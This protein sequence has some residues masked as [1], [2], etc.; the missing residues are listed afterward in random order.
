MIAPLFS[1]SGKFLNENFP[2]CSH[3]IH[4]KVFFLLGILRQSLLPTA[5][6]IPRITLFAVAAAHLFVHYYIPLSIGNHTHILGSFSRTSPVPV[7]ITFRL[8]MHPY[9]YF[10]FLPQ[11]Q[12][13]IFAMIFISVIYFSHKEF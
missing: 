4:G 5:V 13:R 6:L 8:F 9:I 2:G 10:L 12:M 11:F 1:G 3:P 7:M